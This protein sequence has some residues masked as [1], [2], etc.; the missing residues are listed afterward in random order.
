MWTVGCA[1]LLAAGVMW[2]NGSAVDQ[3][4]VRWTMYNAEAV[5][6]MI[7]AYRAEHDGAYPASLDDPD[8]LRH[9]E[10]MKLF[11]THS[12]ALYSP[13]RQATDEPVVVFRFQSEHGRAVLHTDGRVS[14]DR[15]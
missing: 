13:P 1:V 7:E 15:E 14:W 5:G 4:R 12:N 10:N 8:V 9:G 3:T 6:H 11:V 2:F